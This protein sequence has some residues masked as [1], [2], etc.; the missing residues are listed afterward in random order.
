[1]GLGSWIG[2]CLKLRKI[3]GFN[4]HKKEWL[5]LTTLFC[6]LFFKIFLTVVVEE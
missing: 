4:E 6:L 5:V 3:D 1:L 2:G